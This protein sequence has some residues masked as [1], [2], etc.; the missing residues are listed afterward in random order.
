M[1]NLSS[2]RI[3]TQADASAQAAEREQRFMAFLR[4]SAQ[5]LQEAAR[6]PDAATLER[7]RQI[8]LAQLSSQVY[9]LT[10]LPPPRGTVSDRDGK[11]R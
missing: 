2:S 6:H 4:E 1:T 5:R 3:L 10:G 9:E 8:S 11:E 7:A